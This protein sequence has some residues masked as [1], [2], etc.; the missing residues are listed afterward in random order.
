[1]FERYSRGRLADAPGIEAADRGI[2]LAIARQIADLNG[3]TL[4]VDSEPGRGARFV[5]RLA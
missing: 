2:G 4:E 5:L 1:V 3:W